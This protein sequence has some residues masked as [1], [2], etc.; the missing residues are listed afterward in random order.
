MA[1]APLGSKE[2]DGYLKAMAAGANYA[3]ANRQ[4]MSHWVRESF[5]EVFSRSADDMGMSTI[6]DVAHNINKMRGE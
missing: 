5:E 3:W 1:C 6:Y 2:A 4:M